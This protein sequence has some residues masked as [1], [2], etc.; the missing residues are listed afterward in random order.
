M[1]KREYR[2]AFALIQNLYLTL[3]GKTW[4][5]FC[6]YIAAIWLCY[7]GTALCYSQ[8]DWI[9]WNIKNVSIQVINTLLVQEFI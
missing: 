5:D 4:V 6:K 8:Y 1:I 3:M 9:Y 2:S 7:N